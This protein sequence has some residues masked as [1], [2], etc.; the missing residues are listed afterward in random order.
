MGSIS[1]SAK[2]KLGVAKTKIEQKISRRD[3]KA[4]RGLEELKVKQ[5]Y[6]QSVSE[7]YNDEIED[8]LDNFETKLK[9]YKEKHKTR[10]K[11]SKSLQAYMNSFEKLY[12]ENKIILNHCDKNL[13][14][15]QSKIKEKSED[16]LNNPISTKR[17]AIKASELTNAEEALSKLD[18]DAISDC[19]EN[20]RTKEKE[21]FKE[22]SKNSTVIPQECP[23]RVFKCNE[24]SKKRI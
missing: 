3:H 24:L 21:L 20:L 12:K 15:I 2:R 1:S 9:D 17:E 6:Q 16:I 19:L 18:L 5:I 13:Q 7:S 23:K 8:L 4:K 11:N 10:D 22:L 14:E